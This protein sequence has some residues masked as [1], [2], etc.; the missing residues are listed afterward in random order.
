MQAVF[1]GFGHIYWRN[2]L[3][4]TYF[5]VQWWSELICDLWFVSRSIEVD[6][7]EFLY[8]RVLSDIENHLNNNFVN[9]GGYCWPWNVIASLQ[10]ISKVNFHQNLPRKWRFNKFQI[11]VPKTAQMMTSSVGAVRFGNAMNI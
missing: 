10:K 3:W 8:C 5:F 11:P 1:C 2:I 4:K 6:N 9:Q 7:N